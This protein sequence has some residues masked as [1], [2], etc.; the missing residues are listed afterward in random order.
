MIAL[1]DIRTKRHTLRQTESYSAR[2]STAPAYIYSGKSRETNNS[3]MP[4]K[5]GGNNDT[6]N[7]IHIK[8]EQI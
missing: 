5:E 1:T 6:I 7:S 2:Y 4:Y 3:I 8:K